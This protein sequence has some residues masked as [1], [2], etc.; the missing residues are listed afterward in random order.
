MTVFIYII[1]KRN[2]QY[3]ILKS[4]DRGRNVRGS[5]EISVFR[6]TE[7][8]MSEGVPRPPDEA[9]K[10]HLIADKGRDHAFTG[11]KGSG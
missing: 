10:K 9:T 5:A 4:C 11:N 6:P 3:S 8:A 2:T 7:D 1:A